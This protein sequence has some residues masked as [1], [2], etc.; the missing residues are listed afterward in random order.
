M[1]FDCSPS[2]GLTLLMLSN[3]T[4]VGGEGAISIYGQGRRF[5]PHFLHFSRASAG[6]WGSGER[7][8]DY[9]TGGR[10]KCSQDG[11]NPPGV[12]PFISK[13]GNFSRHGMWHQTIQGSAMWRKMSSGRAT[14]EISAGCVHLTR[15]CLLDGRIAGELARTGPGHVNESTGVIFQANWEWNGKGKSIS[16]ILPSEKAYRSNV[17]SVGPSF[18]I[19]DS[20]KAAVH[21]WDQRLGQVGRYCGPSCVDAGR[22]IVCISEFLF[23]QLPLDNSPQIFQWGSSQASFAILWMRISLFCLSHWEMIFGEKW[24]EGT[25]VVRTAAT[26]IWWRIL[27]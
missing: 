25:W 27:E 13:S 22:R 12:F 15:T 9:T 23:A 8:Y 18:G 11:T 26:D 3:I 19:H 20:T 16:F 10:M 4:G 14:G 6:R 1:I 7:R 24:H 2:Y 17:T 5:S 21:E